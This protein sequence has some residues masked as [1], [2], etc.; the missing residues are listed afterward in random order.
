MYFYAFNVNNLQNSNRNGLF[1]RLWNNYKN[2]IFVL[3]ERKNGRKRS[4]G[5]ERSFN[6]DRTN[7]KTTW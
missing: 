2:F 7:D 6:L 3:D 4:I 1:C 5:I